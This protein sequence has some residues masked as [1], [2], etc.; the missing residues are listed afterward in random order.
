[1]R[2]LF[3]IN[4]P[5]QAHLFRPVIAA[6]QARGHACRVVARDKDVTLALLD[7]FGIPY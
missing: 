2:L 5:V 1:M 3:D 6:C 7:A 4:H